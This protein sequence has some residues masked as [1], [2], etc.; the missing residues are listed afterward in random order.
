MPRLAPRVPEMT[1]L[2][3]EA[4]GYVLKGL[5]DSGRCPECGT[6]IADSIGNHRQPP[7]W[8]SAERWGFLRTSV[9]VLFRPTHFYRTL[10]VRGSVPAAR[11]F[12]RWHWWISGVLFA[13][14]A[15]AHSASYRPIFPWLSRLED[16]WFSSIFAAITGC[17][18]L[19]VVGTILTYLM[20]GGIT[21]LAARLTDWEARYRGLRL[22]YNIVL[23]GMYYHAAHYV[24]VAFLSAVTTVGYQILVI[25]NILSINSSLDRYLYVLCG[26]VVVCAMYLFY[27]YWIGMRNMMYANR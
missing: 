13:A 16:R 20:L 1:D 25:K 2:L 22:P 27:T 18:P 26:E 12:A 8:E 11:R 9:E 19:L 17:G 23:R 6:P 14:T 21:R 15:I 10:A 7:A 3:C 5:P 24:P 4:C